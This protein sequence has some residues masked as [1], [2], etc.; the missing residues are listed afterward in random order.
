VLLWT[1]LT[2]ALFGGAITHMAAVQVAR[3]NEKVGLV[4]A[5]RFA[6]GRLR[7]YFFAPILPLFFLA[8]ITMLLVFF[9]WFEGFTWILGDLVFGLFLP[10]VLICGLGMAALLAGV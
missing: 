10:F 8:F 2:W 9:G 7:S 6:R 4:E 1:M 3:Q 5:V